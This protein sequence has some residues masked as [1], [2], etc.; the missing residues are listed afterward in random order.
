MAMV[1]MMAMVTAMAMVTVMSKTV[2]MMAVRNGGDALG[3]GDDDGNDAMAV[4][5]M[6]AMMAMTL[7]KRTFPYLHACRYGKGSGDTAKR[8][9]LATLGSSSTV[10]R[11]NACMSV[12][13]CNLH[14]QRGGGISP[15]RG[16]GGTLCLF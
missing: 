4:R 3:Y 8:N 14:I 15:G 5:L 9:K 10:I 7:W 1:M 12:L 16:V 2:A 13:I 11:W 6:T